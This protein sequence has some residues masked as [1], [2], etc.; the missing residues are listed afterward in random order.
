MTIKEKTQRK[1]HTKHKKQR[2][3]REEREPLFSFYK[4]ETKKN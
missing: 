3:E 4:K 2:K 1:K